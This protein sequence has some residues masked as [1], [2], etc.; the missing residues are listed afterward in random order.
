MDQYISDRARV[1]AESYNEQ[2]TEKHAEEEEQLQLD[3]EV[4]VAVSGA[5][6]KGHVYGF[7]HSMD[8]SRVLSSASSSGS[9]GT[10]AFTKP[11]SLGTSPSEMMGF[12][13]DEIFGL[14]SRL[15]HT[16]HTQVSDAVQA[17]LSQAISQAISQ[18]GR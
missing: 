15:V 1:V 4:W 10:S 14:E 2:M 3:P 11:G 7:R 12:I 16:M 9:Q 17:Q 13:R 6:K 8:T 18:P 5:P